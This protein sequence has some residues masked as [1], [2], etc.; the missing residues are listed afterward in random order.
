MKIVRNNEA[1]ELTVEELR[2][3]HEE[4]Q[5]YLIQ[6]DIRDELECVVDGACYAGDTLE[7]FCKANSM[8]VE[9]MCEE[10]YDEYRIHCDNYSVFGLETPPVHDI[11]VSVLES[12]NFFDWAERA[13]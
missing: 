3:A 7:G 6:H 4:Y 2:D 10:I 5:Q 13:Q 8:S 9:D 1:I 11:V 12:Y